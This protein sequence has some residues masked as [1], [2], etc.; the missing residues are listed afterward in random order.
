MLQSIV[1]TKMTL[2]SSPS[3]WAAENLHFSLYHYTRR[4]SDIGKQSF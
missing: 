4:F 1:L 2:A 3:I